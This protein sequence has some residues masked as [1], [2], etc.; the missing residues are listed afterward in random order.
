LLRFLD[1]HPSDLIILATHGRDGVAHWLHGSIAEELSRTARLPTLFVAP[2]AL[3]FVDRVHGKF[4]L[5]RVL[6]PVDHSPPAVEALG[7]IREFIR[8][9]DEQGAKVELMHVG[10]TGPLIRPAADEG[11]V[12]VA[13]QTGD[14][15]SKIIDQRAGVALDRCK[16]QTYQAYEPSSFIH[17]DTKVVQ[18]KKAAR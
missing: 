10:A 4:H 2:T 7:I 3:G 5:S 13:L 6:V 14:V 11:I 16:Q 1:G 9:M 15:V 17:Q 12:P 8:P 18:Q